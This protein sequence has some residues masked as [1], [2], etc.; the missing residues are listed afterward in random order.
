MMKNNIAVFSKIFFLITIMNFSSITKADVKILS[1]ETRNG[2]KVLFSKSENIPMI[3]I[4]ITFDA[5]SSKDGSLKGLSMLTHN[6]LDEG[7]SKKKSEEIASIFEST[8]SVFNTSVNKDRSTISLRSLTDEKYFNPCL[9]M[10]LE[11]LSDSSFPISEV[12]LQKNRTIS[13]I[14]EDK[15]DPSEIASSIFFKEIY[16]DHPYASQSIGN[17]N[18]VKKINRKNILDFY[19]K[20]ISS[21]NASIAIVSSLPK[22]QVIKISEKI[23][24]SLERKEVENI[25]NTKEMKILKEKYIFKNFKSEQAH[26]YIGSTSI[27]RGS[28]NHIPLYVGNYIFGGSGFSARLMKELRVKR[29]LTYG[30]YSY[31][32]PLKEKGPFLIGIETK[33]EQAQ[34]SVKLIREMLAEFIEK[35]PTDEELKHAKNSIINGFPL[36]IDS[37]SDILNYLSMINYYNLPK[38]YLKTFTSKISK[39]TKKDIINAFKTEIDLDS[40][41]T[42]VVGNEKAK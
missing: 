14:I 16:G 2:V 25:S 21:S 12:N 36:R 31:V 5:G 10:F 38:D 20:H 26:I 13:T 24:K 33:A 17:E 19:Q 23:S 42:L 29:G 34:L 9:K 1:Y 11:I 37:N 3:D 22:D 41:I 18:S 30:V 40:I 15:S 32:Y 27:E 39:V 28:E 8:G 6:L 7:T 35:G 4:K